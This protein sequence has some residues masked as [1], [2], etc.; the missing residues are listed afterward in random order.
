MLGL[1]VNAAQIHATPGSAGSLLNKPR[2]LRMLHHHRRITL[3]GIEISFLK[4]VS[5]LRGHKNLRAMP[6]ALRKSS[7]VIGSSPASVSSSRT[8]NSEMLCSHPNCW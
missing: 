5:R 4:C 8:T 3:N 6:I 2:Q 1:K 7:A